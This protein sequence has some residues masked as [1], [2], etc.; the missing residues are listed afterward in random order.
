MRIHT[1]LVLGNR[2]Q[3]IMALAEVNRSRCN[4]DPNLPLNTLSFK[5]SKVLREALN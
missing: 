5:A 3:P 4:H 1:Q 2:R